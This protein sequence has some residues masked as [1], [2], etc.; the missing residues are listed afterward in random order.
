MFDEY[1]GVDS[2]IFGVPAGIAGDFGFLKRCKKI[3]EYSNIRKIEY[4]LD[5][6]SIIRF[7]DRVTITKSIA[8][9]LTGDNGRVLVCNGIGESL[10]KLSG[11][12]GINCFKCY[13]HGVDFTLMCPVCSPPESYFQFFPERRGHYRKNFDRG[14]YL[15]HKHNDGTLNLKE[16]HL[17]VYTKPFNGERW[18][19]ME[20]RMRGSIP[21]KLNR[22]KRAYADDLTQQD[23]FDRC[24]D[25][26]HAELRDAI[27]SFA[28]SHNPRE[29]LGVKSAKEKAFQLCLANPETR[30][31]FERFVSD[32]EQSGSVSKNFGP[33]LK[34]LLAAPHSSAEDAR[35][36]E[37]RSKIESAFQGDH[38]SLNSLKS[39]SIPR[40]EE[41]SDG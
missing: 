14:F 22:S 36:S 41:V 17:C 18:L 34:K 11:Q 16:D 40:N 10:E 7:G 21:K 27:V 15:Q 31:Q 13:V 5:N 26:L 2:A 6:L 1:L 33:K 32:C 4:S 35:L 29:R 39:I 38:G 19:R 24:A 23:C 3:L 8:T 30:E 20:G 9:Y 25:F 28:P 12:L 37:L